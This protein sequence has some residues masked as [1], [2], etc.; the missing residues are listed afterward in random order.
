MKRFA[1]CLFPLLLTVGCRSNTP[2]PQAADAA[3][4]AFGPS[5]VASSS[6]TSASTSAMVPVNTASPAA[7]SPAEAAALATSSN[8]FATDLYARLRKQPGNLAVSPGS[9]TL[10]LAMTWAGARGDTAR[11]MA[12]VL[13]FSGAQNE[14]VESAARQLATWKD[15]TRTTYTLG[16]ANRLFGE[17]SYTFDPA[18]LKLSS[19]SFK[20]PLEPVDFRGA[21]EAGRQRINGWVAGETRDRIKD[22]LPPRSIDPQT[23]LVLVNAVYFLG[24]WLHPFVKARTRPLPFFA[25]PAKSSDVPMMSQEMRFA[26]G[27]HA[28]VKVLEMPYVGNELAMTLVLPDDK[29]G[30]DAI[31]QNLTADRISAW[32]GAMSPQRVQVTLPVFEVNP[33]TSLSLKET[34]KEMGMPVAFQNGRADFSG[35]ANPPNPEDRLYIGDVFHKAFVR[36]DEKGTE[37][38][39]AT[40]VV[41]PRSGAKMEPE[42][43]VEFRADHPFLFFLRDVRSGMILFMG[44]VNDPAKK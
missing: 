21:H 36:V 13:H 29:G 15:P 5:P 31:E 1:C 7:A 20:A 16:V 34:L 14:V 6:A 25:T 11:E 38:A 24:D 4:P 44:R 41:M 12:R 2:A 30:L 42:K 17:K 32:I 35:I 27:T 23:R 28:G 19:D 39:A 3:Q 9:I 37:A 22:L 18:F 10:A 8:A 33:S 40:A 26:Y 43:T